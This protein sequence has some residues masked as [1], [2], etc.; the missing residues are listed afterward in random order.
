VW[1]EVDVVDKVILKRSIMSCSF[2]VLT[3]TGGSGRAKALLGVAVESA[4]MDEV[5]ELP[6][7]TGT[8]APLLSVNTFCED[9]GCG[10]ECL[11]AS[12]AKSSSSSSSSSM[13]PLVTVATGAGR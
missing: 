5:G 2:V 11:R 12:C 8:R 4:G 6:L 3:G 13:T 7:F 1:G 10:L 9:T